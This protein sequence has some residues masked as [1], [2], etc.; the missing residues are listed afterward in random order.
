MKVP[1]KIK[2]KTTTW[3]TNRTS[4]YLSQVTKITILKRYLHTCVQCSTVYNGQDTETTRE[5]MSGWT[6]KKVTRTHTECH[7]AINRKPCSLWSKSETN[8]VWFHLHV[9]SKKAELVKTEQIGGWQRW[10]WSVTMAKRHK[11][12]VFC[13]RGFFLATP[14]GS[15]DLSSPTCHWTWAMAMKAWNSNHEAIRELHKLSVLRQI[16]GMSCTGWYNIVLY[17]GKFLRE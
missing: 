10:G 12:S 8:T 15:W 6:G 1:H 5:S 9:K 7:S 13:F 3:S 14:H 17:I 2:D 16:L 4:G 11:F